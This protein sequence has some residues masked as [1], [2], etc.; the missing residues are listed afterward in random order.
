MKCPNC[1][2]EVSDSAKFCKYCGTRLDYSEETVL[3]DEEGSIETVNESIA[4]QSQEYDPNE[5]VAIEEYE[6][7]NNADN[8]YSRPE[9][10]SVPVSK[11][12]RNTKL[13]LVL[14]LIMALVAGTIVYFSFDTIKYYACKIAKQDG[15][16]KSGDMLPLDGTDQTDSNTVEDTID[17]E[18]ENAVVEEP[19][20]VID[21]DV[22]DVEPVYEFDS[23]ETPMLDRYGNAKGAVSPTVT[24]SLDDIYT[25]YEDG[26]LIVKK[27]QYYGFINGKGEYTVVPNEYKGIEIASDDCVWDMT[28]G[29][30]EEYFVITDYDKYFKVN[31]NYMYGDEIKDFGC[32]GMMDP[33]YWSSEG[34]INSEPMFGGSKMTGYDPFK[35]FLNIGAIDENDTLMMLSY[36]DTSDPNYVEGII[37]IT[38]DGYKVV[39]EDLKK[40]AVYIRVDSFSDDIAVIVDSN[41]H[42]YVL[43]MDGQVVFESDYSIGVFN[44]GLAPVQN[45]DGLWGYI[46][47]SG[48]LVVDYVFEQASEVCYGDAWV[49]YGGRTGRIKLDEILNN[50]LTVNADL[51]KVNDYRLFEDREV[52]GQARVNIRAIKIR[53]DHVVQDDNQIGR[54]LENQIVNLYDKYED[55]QYTWYEIGQG[56]WVADDGTWLDMQ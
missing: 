27:D 23:F 29:N 54:I 8:D 56:Q 18:N 22:W 47:K 6:E 24:F 19:E 9:T 12:K 44:E 50:A 26:G 14:I 3:L 7:T 33:L 30:Y 20:P 11:P 55:G 4:S 46:D 51:L 42:Y 21:I 17:N 10:E 52:I 40:E 25:N 37:F 5:T 35:E 41:N 2:K 31:S 16:V 1:N 34:Y 39:E 15:C 43:N 38:K 32:G 49:K 53:N 36:C 48:K 45:S 13:P 28:S